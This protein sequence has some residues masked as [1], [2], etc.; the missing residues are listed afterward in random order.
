MA[1]HSYRTTTD[2]AHSFEL[3][4]MSRN[5]SNNDPDPGVPP[6]QHDALQPTFAE[7]VGQLFTAHAAGLSEQRQRLERAHHT[8]HAAGLRKETE[9]L[10]K[11]HQAHVA[12]L[13]DRIAAQEIRIYELE[14][15]LDESERESEQWMITALQG[16]CTNDINPLTLD[17]RT[18][19]QPVHGNSGGIEDHG[20]SG[21][22]GAE[23]EEM[24]EGDEEES[25]AGT[26]AAHPD[27]ETHSSHDESDQPSRYPTIRTDDLLNAVESAPPTMHL[28][29]TR[30]NSS[31]QHWAAKFDPD[32]NVW[33]CPT[34]G[35]EILDEEDFLTGHCPEFAPRACPRCRLQA[36]DE[37]NSTGW[38][39]VRVRS[40]GLD[41][42]WGRR[43]EI[44]WRRA[45]TS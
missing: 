20:G 24:G 11:A 33:R 18:H 21:G 25:G 3:A 44:Y 16:H 22:S 7:T 32:D 37:D 5:V 14:E 13:Q 34:C 23:D 27:P 17:A 31:A 2:D 1:T 8:Q 12:S 19:R 9:R 29:I 26:V 40:A 41:G 38:T 15:A 39:E 4:T 30:S 45:S 35:W 28:S 43:K 10:Q 42:Y 6:T 36:G